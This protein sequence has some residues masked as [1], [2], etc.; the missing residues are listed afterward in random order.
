MTRLQQHRGPNDEGFEYIP[1][2]AEKQGPVVG[3]GHR[4][5]SILDLSPLGHQPMV[6]PQS[7]DVL[8]YNGEIYNF[9]GIRDRLERDGD[10][11][12]GHSDT[13]VLLHALVR[14]GTDCLKDL[15]GMYAFAFFQRSTRRILL[16]RDPLGI[17]PLYI[18]NHSKAWMIA[19]EVRAIIS[20][21]I[22]P[23]EPDR[24]GVAGMLAYGALQD[25]FTFFKGIRSFP[26]GSFQWVEC[27]SDGSV[28]ELPA[29]RHWDFPAVNPAMTAKE[30]VERVSFEVDRAVREHLVSDVPVGVFLSSGIDST[31]IAGLAKRHSP[32]LRTF[33]VGFADEP[34]MA[35]S[36]LARD[37][38]RELNVEHYD[39]QMTG[40]Q[41]EE[42]TRNWLESLDQPSVDGLNTYVIS[43]A[44]RDTGVI[45]AL[46][47]L[48]GDEL[49]GGY[50][51]FQDVPR[52]HRLAK[53]C[54]WLSPRVR[55]RLLWTMA[56]TR[57]ESV[58]NKA[59]EMGMAGAHIPTL[60]FYRRR[61]KTDARMRRLG[62]DFQEM[63][64]TPMFQDPGAS[65]MSP[66]DDDPIAA[67]SRLESRFYMGNTLL[68]DSDTNGMAHSLEIRVPLLDRRVLDL[69]YT[70]PGHIRLPHG[71]ANKELLRVAFREF[72][73]PSLLSQ[74]KRGF[75]LPI[76]RWMLGPLRPMC[77]DAISHIK[78]TEL[79]EPSAVDFTWNTFLRNPEHPVW[80]SAFLFSVLGHYL[81]RSTQPV[82]AATGG[83]VLRLTGSGPL[84]GLAP[85]TDPASAAA[86]GR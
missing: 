20:S 54:T 35:E 71:R 33:T 58:R 5:L 82:K 21:G 18:A 29:E 13:E 11:F 81:R 3:L 4:R 68:R 64:L 14:Y 72:L 8:I 86:P 7:G 56:L 49:F 25:P 79:L 28:H 40:N 42:M 9:Q 77:E 80:A 70:I 60:Y 75:S 38:S 55:A 52:I 26:V 76:R 45:V 2:T 44:V 1:L 65:D 47:G 6:H 37:T 16:A 62:F 31:V 59:W 27:R 69:V 84:P 78:S 22:V 50:P 46:S 67:V 15:A 57:P 53:N 17:K 39:I 43:K 19:S 12:R 24:R 48:G 61:G 23:P 74:K 73:R 32:H 30:A 41:A 83:E 36:D 34:D 85:P 66:G 51:A 63:G 10:R